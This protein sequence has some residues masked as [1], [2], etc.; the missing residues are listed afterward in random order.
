MGREE[1]GEEERDEAGRQVSPA[2][3]VG[4]EDLGKCGMGP[5]T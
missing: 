2:D 1:R 5:V 4:S 3:L